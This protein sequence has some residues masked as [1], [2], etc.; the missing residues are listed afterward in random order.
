MAFLGAHRSVGLRPRSTSGARSA[1]R[2]RA[3][4]FLAVT[5]V[6]AT[7]IALRPYLLDLS[8]AGMS[9]FATCIGVAMVLALVV[10]VRRDIWSVP[11]VCITILVLFLLGALP[12]F[13]LGGR[14][15]VLETN[16]WIFTATRNAS[17][18]AMAA[19]AI[20]ILMSH[21]RNGL[22]KVPLII[23]MALGAFLATLMLKLTIYSRS[24]R[25]D[26]GTCSP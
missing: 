7:L 4:A 8:T 18:L 10:T 1:A 6:M 11:G 14:S 3:A 26:S 17:V 5:A 16:F 15:S 20:F 25:R 23:M 2:Y 22:A 19:L 9:A 21:V 24:R 13:S 12:E